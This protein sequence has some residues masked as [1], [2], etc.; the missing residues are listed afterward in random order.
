MQALKNYLLPLTAMVVV[1]GVFLTVYVVAQQVLRMDAN[2]PQIQLAEDTAAGLD[3]GAAPNMLVSANKVNLE[4]SLAP[5]VIV[6][7]TTGKA[8]ASS[9]YLHGSVPTVPLG[10][11]QNSRQHD[12]IVTWQPARDVRIAS[13]TAA[14]KNYYVLSG[15]S[16]SE[17]EKRENTVGLLALFGWLGSVMVILAASFLAQRLKR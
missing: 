14:A 15:R 5:F 13:V 7:D 10:V 3:G 4:R 1:T 8:V 11:L 17:V 12:N 9:G 2:D 16:L 6:Y